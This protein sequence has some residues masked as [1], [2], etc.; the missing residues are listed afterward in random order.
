VDECK[1]LGLGHS[2]DYPTAFPGMAVQVDP[3]KPTLKAP[4][5]ERLKL[6]CDIMLSTSAFKFKLRRYIQDVWRHLYNE[7]VAGAYSRPL[8]SLT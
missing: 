7:S 8:F 1:S 6:N 2:P 4:G 3:I 5:S